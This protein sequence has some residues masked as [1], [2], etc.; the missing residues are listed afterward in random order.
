MQANKEKR[1]V[2][3]EN[4]RENVGKNGKTG[5]ETGKRGLKWKNVS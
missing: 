1:N 2:E 3:R 5:V 4:A